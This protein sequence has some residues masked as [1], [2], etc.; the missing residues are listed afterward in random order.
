MASEHGAAYGAELAARVCSALKAAQP[1]TLSLEELGKR[2]HHSPTHLQRLFKRATGITP[3][4]YAA[5][6]RLTSFKARLRDG[7][8]VTDA[9]HAA[10]YGSSSRLYDQ[11]DSRLGMTPTAY[12][13]RGVGMTIVFDVAPCPLGQLLLAA[14]ERGICK[15]SLGDCADSLIADLQHEFSAAGLIRD[16]AVA[17]YAAKV[18]GWLHE[19]DGHLHL[20]LDIRATAF[21]LKVWRALQAIPH[22]RDAQLQPGRQRHRPSPKPS[23]PSPTPAPT[24][25][26]RLSSPA[27]ASCGRTAALAA[28]AGAWRA[29]RRCW[30][31]KSAEP[32]RQTACAAIFSL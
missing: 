15:L 2:F 10:G 6:L 3:K 21:Q 9:I 5:D 11:S 31:T 24:I 20:P 12:K 29:N 27:I 30:T 13:H 4:Q 14:T 32:P 26:S 19:A 8:G 18:V 1:D 16:D 22:R 7:D 25:P 17:H 28:I 23:A